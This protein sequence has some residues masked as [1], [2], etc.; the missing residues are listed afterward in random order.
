MTAEQ[1]V[2]LAGLRQVDP[3]NP[4]A[5]DLLTQRLESGKAPDA[6]FFGV[7]QRC[8]RDGHLSESELSFCDQLKIDPRV[9]VR[10]RR[11][12]KPNKGESRF[13]AIKRWVF[14]LD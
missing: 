4:L 3:N 11:V 8:W 13:D 5:F 2:E 10:A 12:V 14:D 6:L 9:Y 7:L 1:I